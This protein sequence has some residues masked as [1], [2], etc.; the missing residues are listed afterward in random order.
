M[1]DR[2][3]LHVLPH[4]GGGGERYVDALAEMQGYRAERVYLAGSAEAGG[5]QL[6]ILGRAL[7]S[8]WA[9]GHD[10][11]HVH[12]EVAAALCL[13]GLATRPS[14]LTLHGLH[15]VRRLDGFAHAVARANLRVILR[16]AKRTICVSQAEREDLRAFVDAGALRRAVVVHNG[17]EPQTSVTEGERAEARA[18]LGVPD[19]AIA[20]AWV[21]ALEEHK[22]PLTPIHAVRGLVSTGIFLLLAGD[23]SMRDEVER[24]AHGTQAVRVLGF[25]DDV[26]PL[27]AASDLV[28]LSSRREGLSFALLEAMSLGLVPVVSDAPGNVETV[29]GAGIVVPFGDVVALANAL[30]ELAHDDSRR[31]ALA[32][33]ARE[34]VDDAFSAGS[35]LEETRRLYDQVRGGQGRA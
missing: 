21:G 11:L 3:V 7:R 4:P 35:M 19:G 25:R 9:R 12:G 5:A 32:A 28:V 13:G 2:S 34:R 27:F 30:S 23:G 26:R 18:Q 6:A 8:Q 17:V 33:K 14:V 24:A 1:A 15:L 10:I 20:C 22:D 29:D 16:A 31:T